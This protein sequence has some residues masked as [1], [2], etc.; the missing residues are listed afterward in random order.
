MYGL[1]YNK[2][3]REHCSV[4]FD[5]PNQKI[6]PRKLQPFESLDYLDQPEVHHT[7]KV[8]TTVF[9]LQLVPCFGTSDQDWGSVDV[10]FGADAQRCCALLEYQTRKIIK[11]VFLTI[12][13]FNFAK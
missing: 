5:A 12:S 4:S 9:V 10:E 1:V 7:H 6:V 2:K 13:N 11:I 8:D 3:S